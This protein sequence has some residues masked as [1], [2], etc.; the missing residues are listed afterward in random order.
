[1]NVIVD[2]CYSGSF[3]DLPQEVSKAGRVVISSTGAWNYA[4]PSEEGAIF[5][6]YFLAGLGQGESLYSSFQTAKWAVLAAHAGL[7]TP[8]LDDDGSGLS[9]EDD[10]E[11]ASQRGFSFAGAP[12]LDE[13]PPYIVAGE[14]PRRAEGWRGTIRAEVRDDEGL[15]RVWALIY[16]PWYE[17]PEAS[18]RLVQEELPAV[19]LGAV[20]DGW[21]AGSYTAFQEAGVYRLVVYAQDGDGLGGRPIT[22]TVHADA[23]LY[24]PLMLRPFTSPY[25]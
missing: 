1:M 18:E 4:Y 12:G 7:Q 5:S 19:E 22:M 2:A 6:D 3:I 25:D 13:W 20:G 10:G 17:P 23:A 24:L 8:W 14:A 21:Y 15:S 9:D 11:E 16:P